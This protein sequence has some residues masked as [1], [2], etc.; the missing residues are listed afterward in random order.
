[1]LWATAFD[2]TETGDLDADDFIDL[3]TAHLPREQ[4]PTLVR[5]VLQHAT[6]RLLPLRV[7]A[8]EAADVVDRLAE[9]CEAGLAAAR[10][11]QVSVALTQGLTG[12]SRDAALLFGWLDAGRTEAGVALDPGMRW[13]VM[14]RL[15]E[16]G[17]ADEALIEAERGRDGSAEAELGAARAL[18]AR[19]TPAAKAAAW[20]AL[21]D[22]ERVSNRMVSA[23]AH[24]LWSPEQTGLV[25]PYVAVYLERAPELARRS[26]RLRQRRGLGRSRPSPWTPPSSPSSGRRS[27]GTCRPC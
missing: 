9:A 13:R 15:A 24:G 17:V 6:G 1:M 14:H 25:A 11:E 21:A 19:P 22:D 27:A 20:N 3:A 18:A 7:P 12:T 16:I 23:L 8:D 26:S 2:L 10:D 5:R 4:H